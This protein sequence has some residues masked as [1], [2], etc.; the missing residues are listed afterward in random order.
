[1][2]I[3][4]RKVLP[5]EAHE[6]ALLHNSCWESAY[7]G[8]I[9]DEYLSSMAEEWMEQR[10]ERYRQAL[11]SPCYGFY[12]TEY[13]G[14]MVGR[15][16]IQKSRDEDKPEAGE[17]MAIYLIEE[18][19]DKG[20]GKEMLNFALSKLNSMGHSEIILWVLEENIRG[21]KFYEKHN[22]VFDGAKKEVEFG[23]PL[24]CLRYA[25][26]RKNCGAY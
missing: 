17:I 1:M 6:Y 24:I 12:C 11:N 15:L 22:F 3:T 25:S 9:P 10:V 5:E 23:K 16:V 13:E 2:G 8:I 20:Y 26:G 19:W 18:F 7:T 21:R 14:K 4:I